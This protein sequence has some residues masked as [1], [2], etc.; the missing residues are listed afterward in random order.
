M[1]VLKGF[2]GDVILNLE[3]IEEPGVRKEF[4]C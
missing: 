1:K 4:A 2:A 3:G